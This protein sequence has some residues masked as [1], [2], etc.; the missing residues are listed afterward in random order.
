[1]SEDLHEYEIK[2]ARKKVKAK[3]K[4]FGNLQSF[5]IVNAIFLIMGWYRGFWNGWI[6][7]TAFWSISLISQYIKAFGIPGMG[8]LDENW[9]QKE[10]E[11]ELGR[12]EE[13]KPEPDHLD[14]D[15]WRQA[16]E[17]I[18]QK[19]WKDSDLV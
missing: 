6:W 12:F 3:K 18:P 14:L 15:D 4:F 8:P 5:L 16:K 11:K 1:M 10:L 2:R 17:K 7:I 9:E 19:N 13:E